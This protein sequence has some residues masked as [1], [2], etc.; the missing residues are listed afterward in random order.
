VDRSLPRLSA[1][2]SISRLGLQVRSVLVEVV[3]Q[4]YLYGCGLEVIIA[5]EKVVDPQRVDGAV[6]CI[7]RRTAA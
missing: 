2:V 5:D 6:S 7:D 3:G 4:Q 1:I